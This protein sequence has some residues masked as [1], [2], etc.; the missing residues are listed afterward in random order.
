M[1][2]P[3]STKR[4]VVG[5]DGSMEARRAAQWA[6]LEAAS[7][8][9]VLRLV[10]VVEPVSDRQED[11]EE[12]RRALHKAWNAVADTDIDVKVESE[13]VSG[14]PADCLIEE[15][16][17][18]AMVCVGYRGTHDSPDGPRGAT[19]IE[20]ARKAVGTVAIIHRPHAK[21]AIDRRKWIVVVLDESASATEALKATQ[22]EAT[23]RHAPILVLES[24][25]HSNAAGHPRHP[26]HSAVARLLRS[27]GQG[28]IQV[29]MLP[30]PGRLANLLQQSACIDQLFVAP[31]DHAALVDELT[32]DQ[33]GRTLRGSDC[34]LLI[35]R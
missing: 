5:I 1:N 33:T 28:G 31:G 15:S 17:H 32:N 19:A 14:R 20:V 22:N 13:V 18:A 35:I 9:A 4:V 7:Q 23:W 34:S 26:I 3:L 11:I 30:K 25:S 29:V 16:R 12:A 21:G 6:A 8:D 27:A 10:Y 2:A 24:W